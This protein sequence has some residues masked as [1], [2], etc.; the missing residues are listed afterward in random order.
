MKIANL[1]FAALIATVIVLGYF[2]SNTVIVQPPKTVVVVECPLGLNISASI[3]QK[4]TE[5]GKIDYS[6]VEQ[7]GEYTYTYDIL[8]SNKE[9]VLLSTP[10]FTK[11]MKFDDSGSN[12]CEIPPDKT[13][14]VTFKHKNPPCFWQPEMNIMS[15]IK[16]K[17][18]DFLRA[19]SLVVQVIAVPKE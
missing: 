8:F 14:H 5:I 7:A 9:P 18:L 1:V 17:D 16:G 11:I 3:R 6:V 4:D 2:W 13:L 19:E 10:F 12:I 15:K